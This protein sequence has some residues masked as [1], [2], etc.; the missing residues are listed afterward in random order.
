MVYLTFCKVEGGLDQ[1]ARI[2][3]RASSNLHPVVPWASL[4]SGLKTDPK[5]SSSQTAWPKDYLVS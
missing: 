4:V 5:G 3:A 2:S 1:Q